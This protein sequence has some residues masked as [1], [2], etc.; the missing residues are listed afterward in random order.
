MDEWIFVKLNFV[1][2]TSGPSCHHNF[3]LYMYSCDFYVMFYMGVKPGLSLQ[4]KNT[5][6]GCLR[7]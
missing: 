4:G 1:D 5:D 2:V 7:T 6:L 3:V